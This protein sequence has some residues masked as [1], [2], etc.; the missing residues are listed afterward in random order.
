MNQMSEAEAVEILEVYA[1]NHR[2]MGQH[3]QADHMAECVAALTGEIAQLRET[4]LSLLATTTAMQSV[5]ERAQALRKKPS[6]AAGS[7]AMFRQMLA[8]YDASISKA[9]T[10]LS[11]KQN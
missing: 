4:A 9:R 7:D 11:A 8:D 6:M 3:N 5:I 1:D 2:T 10:V